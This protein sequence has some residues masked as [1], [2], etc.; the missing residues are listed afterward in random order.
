MKIEF[1]AKKLNKIKADI[2]LALVIGKNLNHKW[3]KAKDFEDISFNGET[4]QISV[5]PHKKKIYIGAESL[6]HEDL[7]IAVGLGIKALDQYKFKSLKIGL[8]GDNFENIKAIAEGLLLGE[9]KYEKHKSKPKKRE[10]NKVIF[11]NEEYSDLKINPEIVKNALKEAQILSEAVLFTRDLVNSTPSELTPVKFSEIAKEMA[12]KH[13]L[14]IKVYGEDF[15]K[16]EGMGAFLA[17]SKASPFPPQLIHLVYK[18][19]NF[20]SK[21]ALVGKGLTYDSGGLSLKPSQAL[22]NM[23]SDE[24]GASAVLG[25]MLAISKSQLPIEVH[26]ILGVTENMIG[27]HAYK[28]DDILKA[29]NGKTIEVKNTDAEGRLVL[30]DCLCYAQELKPDFILD[31]ATLTGACKAALGDYTIGLMG[32]DAG[33]KQSL[34]EAG[35]RSGELIAELPFNRYL[36]QFLK[37]ETADISN[38]PSVRMGDAI[39]AGLF[40]NEFIEKKYKNKWVHLDIAGPAYVEK[41]WA[42][43]SYGASGAGVRIIFEWLKS[44]I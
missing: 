36:K 43:N 27:Q 13:G 18:P 37:S 30:A 32:N 23:K 38:V 41:S 3:V 44:S 20:K 26:A 35:Q 1:Q 39:S 40:L 31:L 6:D 11:S 16:K 42:Y 14:S 28:P 29:K 24:S 19:K 15:L 21:I 33:L 34:I 22:V 4:D 5:L 9:Y 2:E 17:V 8:Y 25:T 12:L 7:R 10:L